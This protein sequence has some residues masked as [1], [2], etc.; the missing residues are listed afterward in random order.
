[1]ALPLSVVVGG[2]AAQAVGTSPSNT[3]LRVGATTEI[4]V[5]ELHGRYYETTVRKAMFAGA[6]LAGVTTSAAFATTYTGMCLTNPI[7]STVN[8]VLTKVSYA[9]LVAQTAGL[10][11]GIMTGYSA[12]TAVTQTT[13]LVPLSNFVGQPAGTG[14]IASATT[15]PVAP[16]RLILLGTLLTGAITVTPTGGTVVDMEGSVVIPAGGF[17]AFYTSAASVASSLVFGMQ[18]EEVSSTI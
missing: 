16:T 13:P 15:L 5:D 12:S 4:I 11:L 3:T 2:T 18:W 9:P 17:A 10:V 8:L 6:N 1:M 14:L 7:G